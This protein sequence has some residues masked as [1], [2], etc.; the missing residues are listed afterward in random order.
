M[1]ES[2]GRPV[3][4]VGAISEFYPAKLPLDTDNDLIRI[5]DS[6]TPAVGEITHLTGTVRDIKGNAVRNAVVEIWEADSN[7]SYIHTRGAAQAGLPVAACNTY[8]LD[9]AC[10]LADWHRR[11][12][13]AWPAIS[14][15]GFD[16]RFRRLWK[17]YLAYCEGGF[18]AGRID[19]MQVALERG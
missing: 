4:K 1:L 10:T 15:L 14:R 3:V 6:L 11:F 16:E 9:Y 5:N 19:V 13:Q 12:E 7:G 17:Y 18:R 2:K 8:G